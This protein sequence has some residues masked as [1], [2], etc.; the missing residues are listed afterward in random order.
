MG[1]LR[2]LIERWF[3]RRFSAASLLVALGTETAT[4]G[5]DAART[6][7]L[8][9]PVPPASNFELSFTGDEAGLRVH[10]SWLRWFGLGER[11]YLVDSAPMAMLARP[12]G[13]LVYR[14]ITSR[15]TQALWGIW[16]PLVEREPLPIFDHEWVSAQAV[17]NRR[18][19]PP[20]EP[21][22]E[23]QFSLPPLAGRFRRD[24]PP[25]P[26]SGPF[27]PPDGS[28]QMPP[29]ACPPVNAFFSLCL[30]NPLAPPNDKKRDTM[31]DRALIVKNA[32]GSRGYHN[33]GYTAGEGGLQTFDQMMARF[34]QDLA[35]V[36]NLCQCELDKVVILLVAHGKPGEL[37]WQDSA[38]SQVKIS[39][40]SFVEA[41]AE[42]P[43]IKANPQKFVLLVKS[44]HS[45]QFFFNKL[46]GALE[47]M[48]LV[49]STP[50]EH[51]VSY[52]GG[53]GRWIRDALKNPNV[54]TWEDF[55]SYILWSWRH[56]S[57]SYHPRPNSGRI[58][59]CRALATLTSID[60]SGA[61][62][63][64]NW[65]LEYLTQTPRTIVPT[66]LA[67]GQT[68][69]STV[70][71]DQLTRPCDTTPIRIYVSLQAKIDFQGDSHSGFQGAN[72]D[73][74]CNP[75]ARTQQTMII[76]VGGP[77]GSARLTAA[78]ELHTRCSP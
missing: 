7:V 12:L 1:F 4:G 63:G 26:P 53:L 59:G 55:L 15:P 23:I 52:G 8:R 2:A 43:E 34:R 35:A 6:A 68:T 44:C 25:L 14:G 62:L 28:D 65:S 20:D 60:Y 77:G 66:T 5:F 51:G 18:A 24:R 39:F 67:R 30:Q 61:D 21:F 33:R 76:D 58:V 3:D 19:I 9:V 10:Q 31:S 29:E 57:G 32:F 42:T 17:H 27:V 70:L 11:V 46:P 41:L 69:M 48:N 73:Q 47:G 36:P 37:Q 75:G 56:A 13:M 71:L 72:V 64:T 40:D 49:T 78:F 54:R 74:V 16:H 50:D 45:G 38:A 22:G